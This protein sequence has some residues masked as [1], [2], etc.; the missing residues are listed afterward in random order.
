MQLR[1]ICH[2]RCWIATEESIRSSIDLSFSSF[3]GVM[4]T[5]SFEGQYEQLSL[6]TETTISVILHVF[7]NG[8]V[9]KLWKGRDSLEGR[10]KEKRNDRRPFRGLEKV[11]CCMVNFDFWEPNILCSRERDTIR[12]ALIDPERTFWGDSIADWVPLEFFHDLPDKKPSLLAYNGISRDPVLVTKEEKIRFRLMKEYLAFFMEVEK[13]Y[14]YSP[15]HWGWWR[16]HAI[17]IMLNADVW[18]H[19]SRREK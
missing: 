18:K 12:Y 1:Q 6:I 7:Q 2:D 5:R 4:E 10:R 13:Y 17:S 9:W 11:P 15:F 14:R 16:N 3:V 8:M 19:L